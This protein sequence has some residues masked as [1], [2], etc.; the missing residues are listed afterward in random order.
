MFVLLLLSGHSAASERPRQTPE[1]AKTP[2]THSP[3][4]QDSNT[5]AASATKQPQGEIDIQPMLAE[6]SIKASSSA[7]SDGAETPLLSPAHADHSHDESLQSTPTPDIATDE[8]ALPEHNNDTPPPALQAQQLIDDL[9]PLA[10]TAEI[11]SNEHAV[12]VQDNNTEILASQAIQAGN[13]AEAY[14]LWRP[15]AEAGM[16]SAQYGIGWMYHNGYGLAIDDE[17]AARW[18][19]RAAEQG[20]IEALFALGMLYSLGEG[21]VERAMIR[22]V[23]YYYQAAQQGHEDA[24]LLLQGLLARNNPHALDLLLLKLEQGEELP[25]G[26]SLEVTQPRGNIRKGVGTGTPVLITVEQGEPLR[27][28]NKKGKWLQV[29]LPQRRLV[30]WIHRSLVR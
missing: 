28:F 21:Q 19:E 11:P 3:S 7:H 8:H 5:E 1:S 10:E 25:F 22:A 18:W 15:L 27:Q 20:H 23:D 4:E 14:Y 29:L 12:P 17:K 13:F 16:A 30:G 6:P 2:T 9:E 24:R 26:Q